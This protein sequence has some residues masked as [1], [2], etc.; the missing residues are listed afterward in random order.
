VVYTVIAGR[1][2][3]VCAKPMAGVLLYLEV[4]CG[5]V[6]ALHGDWWDMRSVVFMILG[7]KVA[8]AGGS[9]TVHTKMSH[10]RQIAI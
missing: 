8:T 6:E 9:K 3:G 2:C 1:L 5:R 10:K 7:I 4:G